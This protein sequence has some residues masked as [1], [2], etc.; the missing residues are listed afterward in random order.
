[1]KKIKG[2][3]ITIVILSIL[4]IISI[5]YIIYDKVLID[6]NSETNEKPL[7]EE[8][9][10][11]EDEVNELH[12]TLILDD[13]DTNLYFNKSL[14]VEN[15]YNELI[16]YLLTFY[17]DEHNWEEKVEKLDEN[18]SAEEFSRVAEVSKSTIDDMLKEKFN[19][20][21]SFDVKENSYL[22]RAKSIVYSSED[23]MFY[24]DASS[25]GMEYGGVKAKMLK[26]EQEDDKLYIYDK[27]VTCHV[28]QSIQSTG[29][30][31]GGV[32][33]NSQKFVSYEKDNKIR[34]NDEFDYDYIFNKYSNDLKTYKTTFKKS[35]NGKYYWYSLEVLN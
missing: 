20:D 6:F 11:T 9:K 18:S 17:A 24:L 27:V 8:V 4:L 22:Y 28:A 21:K 25:M 12:D 33:A 10:L 5:G 31:D 30:Y 16:S 29:C 14:S 13:D 34:I 7:K 35:S 26:Y 3:V 15:D 1:M 19:V 2:L 32:Y 23:E